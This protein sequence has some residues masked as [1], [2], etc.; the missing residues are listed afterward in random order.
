MRLRY[1]EFAAY[2]AAHRYRA[3]HGHG[4]AAFAGGD[5]SFTTE[6]GSAA[7]S[8]ARSSAAGSR[9]S[10]QHTLLSISSSQPPGRAYTHALIHHGDAKPVQPQNRVL[11]YTA[12]TLNAS[13]QYR[14]TLLL[15]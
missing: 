6:E 5:E 9:R 1:E 8:P 4:G 7:G 2:V 13:D 15:R 10:S 12:C 11:F 14:V 3:A